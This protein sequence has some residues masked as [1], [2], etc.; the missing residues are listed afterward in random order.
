MIRAHLRP[1]LPLTAILLLAALPADA[2]SSDPADAQSSDPVFLVNAFQVDTDGNFVAGFDLE[3]EGKAVAAGDAFY[4]GQVLTN[5]GRL[6]T[7]MTLSTGDTLALDASLSKVIALDRQERQCRCSCD[8]V[9]TT[10]PH[11]TEAECEELNNQP[12]G[13]PP[14]TVG[15][16][17][18]CTMR[19]VTALSMT[20]KALNASS[21]EIFTP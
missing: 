1:F 20:L 3:I 18:R 15:S 19:W 17:R 16:L 10:Y 14:G 6:A 8:G 11:L 2:Q 9:F 7:V 12:C 5:R 21:A 4:D 13:T